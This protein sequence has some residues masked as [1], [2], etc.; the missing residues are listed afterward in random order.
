M[1]DFIFQSRGV[2]ETIA[3]GARLASHLIEKD[4]IALAGDLGAGK[5]HLSKGIAAGLGVD[6]D[7]VNSPTFVLLQQYEG[8]WPVFHFDTYR[9][10]EPSEFED[11]GGIEVLDQ[12]GISLIEWPQRIE[13][14]LPE[15]RIWIQ[16]TATDAETRSITI[17][18]DHP[19]SKSLIAA[20]QNESA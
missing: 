1:S 17:R 15:R 16:V 3:F 9:L 7:V 18:A 11:I 14:L 4:V 10:G 20:L 13:E 8:R 2:A 6:P 12:N 19:R 5:T